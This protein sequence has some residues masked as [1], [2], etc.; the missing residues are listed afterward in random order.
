MC[1]NKRITI[2]IASLFFSTAVYCPA[3]SIMPDHHE[4]V[5]RSAFKAYKT[6]L[7]Q[8]EMT[9]TLE[10]GE[11]IIVRYSGQEDISPLVD[12]FF[13][14]HFF[15]ANKN[16]NAMGRHF[17]G[18]RKSLHYIF[19]ERADSLI[20]AL[21]NKHYERVYEYTGRLLHY[22]QDMSVPAHVAPIFHYKFLIFDQSDYFDE[23]PE[24]DT[25][26]YNFSANICHPKASSI[27]DLRQRLNIIL[28]RT[29]LDTINRV[30]E[31]IPVKEDH[32]LYGETWEVFWI[33]R[34][35]KNDNQ[36][37]NTIKGFAPYG[38]EGNE[39]FKLFCNQSDGSRNAC[40]NF[41]QRS[42]DYTISSSIETLLLINFILQNK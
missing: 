16:T 26:T 23:M 42:Y 3:H 9:D 22:M 7:K 10:K 40:L 32:P 39:G 15:D 33:I 11:E 21:R 29:A 13:N 1:E 38:A 28:N 12:R 34:N 6:C 20:N 5:T 18:A 31:R 27:D 2:L 19:D 14:W 35:P 4:M 41:F 8:L 30:K 25:A 24:W 36:Y 17:T 37:K